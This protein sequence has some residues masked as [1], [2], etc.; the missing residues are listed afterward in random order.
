MLI[1]VE[2]PRRSEPASNDGD[3]ISAETHLNSGHSDV[4]KKC[5]RLNRFVISMLST[6]DLGMLPLIEKSATE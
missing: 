2:Q 1:I 5:Q 6:L 4:W 3:Q